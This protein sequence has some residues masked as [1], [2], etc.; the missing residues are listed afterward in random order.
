M[1]GLTRSRDILLHLSLAEDVG[2]VTLNK[3]LQAFTSGGL[4]LESL[5]SLYRMNVSDLIHYAHLPEAKAQLIVRYLAHKDLLDRELELITTHTITITTIL[6]AQ[7]PPLL[8]Q[9]YA[10]PIILYSKGTADLAA[11]QQIAVVG[12]RKGDQYG[13]LATKKLVPELVQHKWSIVSGGA[14]GIDSMAHT[15]ALEAAGMTVA[16]LGSGLLRPYPPSNKNLFIRILERNGSLVSVF[17]L[18]MEVRPEFFPARNR[19][20]AGL[21]RGC[22]VIQAAERSG[23]LITAQYALNEGREVFATPGHIHNPLSAGCHKLIQEG[24]TLVH[25]TSDILLQFG[26]QPISQPTKSDPSKG[27]VN[28]TVDQQ[29]TITPRDQVIALCSQPISFEELAAQSSL[30]YAQLQ[31]LLWDLMLDGK[32]AQSAIGYWKRVW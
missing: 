9:I 8:K 26:Q 12:S 31:E 2:P 24:A 5:D 15:E 18:M 25:S 13:S 14:V 22:L 4:A 30:S 28:A 27:T 7:Y 20:I 1:A 23:A 3:L 21:S 17:P 11:Q 16:V 6:D 32:V 19:I 10:P 29:A